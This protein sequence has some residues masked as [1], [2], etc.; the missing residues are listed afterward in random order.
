[1]SLSALNEIAKNRDRPCVLLM[2]LELEWTGFEDSLTPAQ[3]IE[4]WREKRERLNSAFGAFLTL[5]S[6]PRRQK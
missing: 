2:V 5:A 1:M 3:R 6:A 4:I